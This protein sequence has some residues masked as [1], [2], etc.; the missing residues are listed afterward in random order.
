MGRG[1]GVKG[2]PKPKKRT[3]HEESEVVYN[4]D[5]AAARWVNE[6]AVG[7]LKQCHLFQRRLDLSIMPLIDDLILIAAA[8]ANFH[9]ESK[10]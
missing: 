10:K 1:H 4:R 8:L 3:Q 7:Q 5:V 9:K 2:A 6:V